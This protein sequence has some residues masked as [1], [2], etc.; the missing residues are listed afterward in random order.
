MKFFQAK[1]IFL[2]LACIFSLSACAG[3][4]ANQ[5]SNGANQNS[6]VETNANV[7]KDDTEEFGKVVNLTILPEEVSWRETNAKES[8][9]LIAVLRFSAADAQTIVQQAEKYKPAIASVVDAE[10]WFPP[11]LIAKSQQTGDETLKG[12]QYAADDFYSE[13]YKSGKLTRISDTNFF[14]LELLSQ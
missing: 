10:D 6:S 12:A 9:K 14:V 11:E 5:N 2:S 7:V 4:D 3:K 1:L 13:A 8:K